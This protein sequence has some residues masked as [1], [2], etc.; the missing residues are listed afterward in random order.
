MLVFLFKEHM[1]ILVTGVAGFIGFHTAKRLL[2]RGDE[3]VG[4]DNMN[5]Y[6]EPT[7]KESRLEILSKYNNFKF[8]ELD[9]CDTKK[10]SRVFRGI[11]YVIHLAAQAGVRYSIECPETYYQSNIIGFHSVLHNCQVYAPKNILYASS[12]SVYGL[13]DVQPFSEDQKTDS[14][15]SIYAVTKKTNELMAHEF[16]HNYKKNIV[17]L[18]FFTVYGP[19]GRP[20]MALFKFVKNI[21]NKKPITVY[22]KGLMKR[23]FTY[24]D[25]IVD[26]IVKISDN[27]ISFARNEVQHRVYNIGRGNPVNLIDFIESI[28]S[29]LGIEAK[30]NFD[31]MQQGDVVE[32]YADTSA[33]Q[34]DFGYTPTTSIDTGVAKFVEWYKSYY[35]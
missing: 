4:I 16:S 32:T 14:P 2:D 28:Q 1:K 27:P 11:E 29:A 17:G 35:K 10:L 15:V 7:L 19:W 18:R 25:D 26:G 30:V 21:L 22:N 8:R 20:D 12:S 6:Y 5:E 3:V 31:V 13:N 23:D 33:L 9:I 24:I 34:R